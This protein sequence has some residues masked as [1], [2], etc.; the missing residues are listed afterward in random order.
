ML[1]VLCESCHEKVHTRR[2]QVI[3]VASKLIER[4]VSRLNGEVPDFVEYLHGVL[5]LDLETLPEIPCAD[6][7][8]WGGTQADLITPRDVLMAE[9]DWVSTLRQKVW[10]DAMLH[11][12][13]TP[14]VRQ[15]VTEAYFDRLKQDY[16]HDQRL[17]EQVQREAQA[18]VD[19]PGQAAVGLPAPQSQA[20][21]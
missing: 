2:L 10:V 17:L 16:H 19:E 18:I 13:R 21:V 14:A 15:F 8:W 5:G 12:L 20:E 1:Y 7:F 9:R 6:W 4:T 3:D 11:M